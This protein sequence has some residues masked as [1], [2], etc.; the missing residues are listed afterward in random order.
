[1]Y[2]LNYKCKNFKI[3]EF[4]VKDDDICKDNIQSNNQYKNLRNDYFIDV[5]NDSTICGGGVY[6]N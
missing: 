3:N 5:F 6:R 1:M 2:N 4:P